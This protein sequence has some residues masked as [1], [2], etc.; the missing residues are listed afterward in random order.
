MHAAEGTTT[1]INFMNWGYLFLKD[2]ELEIRNMI[3][4]LANLSNKEYIPNTIAPFL[5]LVPITSDIILIPVE[6]VIDC[7]TPTIKA[8]K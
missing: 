6:S 8:I 5:L 2:A 1:V 3:M 4:P 7:E